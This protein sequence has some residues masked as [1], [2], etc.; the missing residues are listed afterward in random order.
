MANCTRRKYQEDKDEA[1][2]SADPHHVLCETSPSPLINFL[3]DAT[4]QLQDEKDDVLPVLRVKY[5]NNLSLVFYVCKIN[6]HFC[7]RA[8]SKTVPKL[9]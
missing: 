1:A 9:Y 2:T 3:L 5:I 6:N 4:K 8:L 7:F